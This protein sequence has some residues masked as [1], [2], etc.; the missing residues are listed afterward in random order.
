MTSQDI[1]R[2][3]QREIDRLLTQP[4]AVP[5]LGGIASHLHLHVR[6]LQRQLAQRNVVFRQ[7]LDDRRRRRAMRE[8]AVR[9]RDLAAVA[10]QLGYS[11]QAHFARAFRRWTGLSPTAYRHAITRQAR[12]AE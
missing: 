11:D 5:T 12:A 8:V 4:G 6:T 9:Q 3:V 7:L 10:A 2:Q 1:V